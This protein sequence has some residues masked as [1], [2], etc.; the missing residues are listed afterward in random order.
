[1]SPSTDRQLLTFVIDLDLLDRIDD[2]RFDNRF[3][4]RAGAIR[5]LLEWSLKKSPKP[6]KKRRKR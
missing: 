4:T 3:P 5:W 1:M 6:A 2:F